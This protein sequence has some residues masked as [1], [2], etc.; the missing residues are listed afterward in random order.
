MYCVGPSSSVANGRPTLKS[1]T[2]MASQMGITLKPFYPKMKR[3]SLVAKNTATP[4]TSSAI[5]MNRLI[6]GQVDQKEFYQKMIHYPKS[7]QLRMNRRV[8]NTN[9]GSVT[10]N[11]LGATTTT[12]T[13]WTIE[14]VC[15]PVVLPSHV[16]V[17]IRMPKDASVP[18]LQKAIQ[19]LCGIPMSMQRLVVAGKD[20]T[21][22]TN[23]F[24][25]G[26]MKNASVTSVP[27]VYVSTTGYVKPLA[28]T[29]FHAAETTHTNM[30]LMHVWCD[31]NNTLTTIQV[32]YH[33]PTMHALQFI[34]DALGI[35]N[36]RPDGSPRTFFYNNLPL[37][38]LAEGRLEDIASLGSDKRS[39]NVVLR[40]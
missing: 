38:W 6:R 2:S 11:V 36:C 9:G 14:M 7:S 33:E 32:D 18:E 29:S 16:N 12:T 39:M 27:S 19:R 37:P 23:M 24:Q 31:T 35:P 26:D 8:N 21:D 34:C 5:D 13:T 17:K 10:T 22:K 28:A 4:Y 20:I 25:Y 40:L 15:V 3:T 1:S 30:G